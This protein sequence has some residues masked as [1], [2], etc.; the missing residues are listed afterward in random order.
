MA[1]DLPSRVYKTSASFL[2]LHSSSVAPEP[3]LNPKPAIPKPTLEPITQ[4]EVL[5]LLPPTLGV[6][7]EEDPSIKTLEELFEPLLD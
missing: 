4:E 7:E 3:K 1:T 5:L 2:I 6:F